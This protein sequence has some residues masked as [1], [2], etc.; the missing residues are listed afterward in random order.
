MS[1]NLATE[2]RFQKAVFDPWFSG[3][4]IG[5]IA[6]LMPHSANEFRNYTWLEIAGF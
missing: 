1:K 4:T 6:G 5:G 2:L 3:E